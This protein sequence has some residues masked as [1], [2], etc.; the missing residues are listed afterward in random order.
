M[1]ATAL[2]LRLRAKP[3]PDLGFE[4]FERKRP[5]LRRVS[6]EDELTGAL[7]A[8]LH[9]SQL[10]CPVVWTELSSFQLETLVAG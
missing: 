10:Q 5:S 7:Y 4:W 6:W 3:A 8:A 9:F 1:F 2:K